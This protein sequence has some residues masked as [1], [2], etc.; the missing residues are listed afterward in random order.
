ML[1]YAVQPAAAPSKPVDPEHAKYMTDKM[2]PICSCLQPEQP[3][4]AAAPKPAEPE[5]APEVEMD[6]GEKEKT[7]RK[8]DAIKEKEAG[9]AVS[10]C[11]SHFD[12][13]Q[14]TTIKRNWSIRELVQD[15]LLF[16]TT[17]RTT[18]S[19]QLR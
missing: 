16:Y 14:H 3:K 4:P 17:S 18:P 12:A 9:N 10:V 8:A 6:D 11:A 15:S 2:S 1:S 5:P 13:L 7:Q 19:A